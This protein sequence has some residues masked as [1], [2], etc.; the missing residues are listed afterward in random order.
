MLRIGAA[1]LAMATVTVGCATPTPAQRAEVLVH[2][3]TPEL[4]R[5]TILIEDD[6]LDVEAMISTERG[7]TDRRG[8]L[9]IAWDDNFLR[10]YV[11]KRTGETRIQVY[12]FI[13]YEGNWRFYNRVN[14]ETPTGPVQDELRIVARDVGSCDGRSGVC[15]HIESFVFDVDEGLLRTIAERYQPGQMAAWR[16]KFGAQR[17]QDWQGGLLPAE[18]VGFLAALD[19]YRER[20]GLPAP[21]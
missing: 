20:N 8:L 13:M 15:T 21:Q 12:Q 17:H 10:A 4:F 11:D 18:I 14:Y 6:A 1:L 19:A 9:N 2:Q 3:L 7:H 16:F 5:R